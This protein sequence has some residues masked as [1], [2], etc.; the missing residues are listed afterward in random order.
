MQF[1]TVWNVRKNVHI[2]IGVCLAVFIA[3]FI[4][5]RPERFLLF[6]L[7]DEH[8]A[9]TKGNIHENKIALTFNI[10][11]GDEK[12]HDILAALAKEK[13]QATFFVSG[14]WAERH[15]HILEKIT[16]G[17]HEVAM[18]GYRYKNYIEQ[19]KEQVTKDIIYAKEIFRKLGYEDIAY[20]RPPHGKFDEEIIEI[21]NN[22]GLDV[23]YWSV[24][25]RDFD[26]INSDTIAKT[27]EKETSGGD[28]IL[29]HASDAAKQTAEAIHTFVPALKKKDLTFVT[30]SQL[31]T[32]VD[33][34]EKLL[35]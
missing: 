14:E 24:N 34:K 32:A 30:M 7:Q 26:N 9:L 19:E 35:E 31:K 22:Q 6:F 25:P 16:D 4:L 2:I 1:F 11:W 33:T 20:I 13:V 27:I 15:P 21:A 5:L 29:L 12:V 28:I 18:L 23:V 8:V 3:F 10:S 17:N